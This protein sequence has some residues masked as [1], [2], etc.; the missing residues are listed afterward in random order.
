[1]D[2]RSVILVTGSSSGFGRVSVERLAR[3]GHTVFASM[4]ES[5]GRNAG[6]RDQLAALA[7]RERLALEVIDLDVT[8]QASV[9]R[10]VTEVIDKAGRI[11]VLVNNAGFACFG[12]TEEFSVE[13]VQRIFDTNFFGMVRMNRAALPHMRERNCG[14]LVHI[15]SGAGRGVLPGMGP[16]TATKFAVEALAETYRYELSQLGV[17]SIIIEPG[18]FATEIFDKSATPSDRRRAAAYGPWAELPAR[19]ESA[20][21]ASA[22]DAGECAEL[23]VKL[24]EMPAGQRPFRTLLGPVVNSLQPLNDLSAQVQQGILDSLGMGALPTV[25]PVEEREMIRPVGQ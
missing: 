25:R 10:A 13:E 5:A 24:V 19:T 7:R 4:R 11:D 14:L 2:R 12:L 1:M 20:L 15:S 17:E 21:T 23:L 18:P 16:Y 8:N 9:D 6:A 3:K 22:V